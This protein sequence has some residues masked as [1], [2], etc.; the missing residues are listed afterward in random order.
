MHGKNAAPTAAP[1]DGMAALLSYENE[2]EALQSL[3]SFF[4]GNIGKF[5]H[6]P[7]ERLRMSS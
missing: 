1:K 2:A 4:A 5:R 6:G 3:A 7:A